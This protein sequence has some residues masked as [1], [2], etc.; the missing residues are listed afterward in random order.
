MERTLKDTYS[1]ATDDVTGRARHAGLSDRTE[2]DEGGR[3]G[4]GEHPG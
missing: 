2:V 4:Y 3:R 1:V